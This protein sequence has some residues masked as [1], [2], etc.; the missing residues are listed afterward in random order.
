[1]NPRDLSIS[2]LA[3]KVDI[4]R[5]AIGAPPEVDIFVEHR[6]AD[7]RGSKAAGSAVM[8][9]LW[10]ARDQRPRGSTS[11]FRVLSPVRRSGAF[12]CEI[13]AASALVAVEP[14]DTIQRGCNADR[15][16]DGCLRDRKSSPLV[17]SAAGSMASSGNPRTIA[18]ATLCVSWIHSRWL[19]F[20]RED[21]RS[22]ASPAMVAYS[23]GF[24]E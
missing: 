3:D 21:R 14:D 22:V 11:W 10:A 20:C 17:R 6:A 2:M 16:G 24:V 9:W 23:S 8:P 5:A 12:R 15:D 13:L 19:I 1:M 4:A 7:V 18:A